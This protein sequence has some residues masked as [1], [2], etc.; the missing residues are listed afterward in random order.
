M[1]PQEA[2]LFHQTPLALA[3]ELVKFVPLDPNDS[4]CEPFKGEGAFYNHFPPG[5]PT[6]WAEIQQGKDFKDLSGTYDWV[7]SNPPFRLQEGT[8]RVNSFWFLLDYFSR[9]VRKGIA[10]LGNQDCF[11]TLTPKR[12]VLLEARGL[13]LT[14]LVVCTV[15]KWRGRY[16]FMVFEKRN[17]QFLSYLEQSF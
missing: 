17:P 12:L 1:N 7:I 9:K 8:Q 5:H 6:D 11:G 10:F 3:K 14:K 2:Y 13:F 4:L 16:Y 15:K